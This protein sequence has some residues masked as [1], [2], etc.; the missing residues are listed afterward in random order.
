MV[1]NIF[2]VLDMYKY[3]RCEILKVI[4]E[5]K[6]IGQMPPYNLGLSQYRNQV[7]N[8]YNKIIEN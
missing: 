5:I 2:L 6:G 3:A 8:A 4:N 7:W 1:D